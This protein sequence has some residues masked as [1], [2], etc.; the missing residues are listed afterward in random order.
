M[1]P[2]SGL[3]TKYYMASMALHGC[4]GFNPPTPVSMHYIRE[5]MKHRLVETCQWLRHIRFCSFSGKHYNKSP[6][7]AYSKEIDQLIKEMKK[8]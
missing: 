2:K 8:D 6:G 4:G 1:N 3:V 5:C 7:I